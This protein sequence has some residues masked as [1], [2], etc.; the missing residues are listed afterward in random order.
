VRSIVLK[1]SGF[2]LL[3]GQVAALAAFGLGVMV[4]ASLRFRK[5]L[6]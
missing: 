6:D 1:G 3:A 5:R 2:E 4:L